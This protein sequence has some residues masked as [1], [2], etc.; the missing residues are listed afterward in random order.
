MPTLAQRDAS[1][2]F[3]LRDG[4]RH[5]VE[6]RRTRT[7]KVFRCV[8]TPEDMAAGLH[9]Y[10]VGAQ[11][12][13]VHYPDDVFA[14]R[15]RWR[16]IDCEIRR[17][18]K[19]DDADYTMTECGYQ[20]RAW[21]GKATGKSAAAKALSYI[22]EFSRAG[23]SYRM[24][25]LSLS[26]IAADGAEEVIARPVAGI[27]PVL[28]AEAYSITWPGAF[29]DGIDYGYNTHP[30]HMFKALIVRER[31][32][33]PEPRK[34]KATHLLLRLWVAWDGDGAPDTDLPSVAAEYQGKA[35]SGKDLA[36]KRAMQGR[37]AHKRTDG[38]EC[39]WVREPE[40]WERAEDG[41]RRWRLDWWYETRGAE[42]VLCLALPVTALEAAQYPL[43]M[44]TDIAEEQV[45]AGTDDAY[46]ASDGTTYND[47]STVILVNDNIT[48]WTSGWRWTTL[49]I[50]A[51]ATI[52]TASAT[53]HFYLEFVDD[54]DVTLYFEDSDSAATFSSGDP[55]GTRAQTAANVS[56]IAIDVGSSWHASP[57]ISALVQEVVDRGGWAS[58]QDMAL[59]VVSNQPASGSCM[60]STYDYAPSYG[61]KLNV[62]YT[63]AGPVTASRTMVLYGAATPT[64]SRVVSAYAGSAADTARD[65][66]AY[67][68]AVQAVERAL[69]LYALDTETVARALAAYGGTATSDDAAVVTQ[70]GAVEAGERLV[71]AFAGQGI[72]ISQFVATYGA[73]VVDVL[74]SLVLHAG[75]S[76]QLERYV[77]LAA[78]ATEQAERTLSLWGITSPQV[79]R[80]LAMYAMGGIDVSRLISTYG[81]GVSDVLRAILAQAGATEQ[82]ERA[83]EAFAAATLDAERA[84]LAYG[85]SGEHVARTL[86][87]I[88]GGQSSITRVLAAYGAAVAVVS[89]AV[90]LDAGE[91][92]ALTRTL[93][94][95][96]GA[97]ESAVQSVVAYGATTPDTERSLELLS[98]TL[99]AIATEVLAWAGTEVSTTWGVVL[100]ADD[101]TRRVEVSRSLALWAMQE[102]TA[103]VGARL[104]AATAPTVARPLVGYAG[105]LA[106]A[107]RTM[108]L[109][110]GGHEDVQR[111]TITIDV[112]RNL[113]LIDVGAHGLA[114]D[115]APHVLGIDVDAHGLTI[116]LREE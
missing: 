80:A 43:V 62:S 104:V 10:R 17:A 66:A 69:A 85:A 109:W 49:P 110:G 78:G 81:A 71:A 52:D 13:P 86:A 77:L 59:I 58:G 65:L 115:A 21:Q 97:L 73:G 107:S 98:A 108:R 6:S 56:W 74:R 96:A 103:E 33:L 4:E 7:A 92:Q 8:E 30:D 22:G 101:A 89:R 55:P 51:G 112:R 70:A 45:G 116:D 40:A 28:D 94:T 60:W 39:F 99:N 72:D 29:G 31:T 16:E 47:S 35:D 2:T 1:G 48:D 95:A 27:D 57:D 20:F 83:I 24:A 87:A 9:R 93:Q 11:V 25:P 3:A 75:A 38:R 5:E 42:V 88:A 64:V 90:S 79:T 32:A 37:Y 114:L 15:P 19:D 84:L 100:W 105:A 14:E 76:E 36:V 63:A 67:A 102:A 50:P 26:W 91:Q 46:S 113:L 54:I 82:T 53:P 106:T 68:A 41:Q 61:A 12:G 23:A 18:G 111:H 34:I 44:D